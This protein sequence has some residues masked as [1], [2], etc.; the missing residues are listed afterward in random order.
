MQWIG[1]TKGFIQGPFV[2]EGMMLAMIGASLAIGVLAG[3]YYAIPST[4]LHF[5]S[6]QRGLDFL[7]LSLT[8]S[9]I[10]GSGVLGLVGS[11]VSVNKFLR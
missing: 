10:L 9:M 11:L 5:L 8:A 6:Q 3:L 2:L 1:A 7:P 4:V